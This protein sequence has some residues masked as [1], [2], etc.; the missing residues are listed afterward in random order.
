[1]KNKI[2][3]IAD[4]D[5]TTHEPTSKFIVWVRDN[6][7]KNDGLIP[8]FSRDQAALAMDIISPQS[9]KTRGRIQSRIDFACYRLGL[10][11]L[12]LTYAEPYDG[13]WE[14]GNG[15]RYSEARMKTAAR[16]KVWTKEEFDEV[17][18]FLST[19]RTGSYKLWKDEARDE[20]EKIQ[21]WAD[22]FLQFDEWPSSVQ[23]NPG[24]NPP[25]RREELILAL[26][27][28][29][30]HRDVIPSK[31]ST[32][33]IYLSN[34]LNTIGR[35]SVKG[36]TYRNASG[37]YMKLMNFRSIDP[38][39]TILGR[40]GLTR[41]NKDEQVVWDL[42]ANDIPR[43]NAIVAT[44]QATTECDPAS[45]GIEDLDEN[46]IEDC[47]EGR[48]LTR[49]HRYRERNRDL[50]SRFKARA[51]VLNHGTL[52][53]AACDLEYAGKYGELAEKLIDV[54]HTK[55]IHTMVP[56]EKTRIKD[57]VLLC[58]CCHRAIHSKRQWLQ[59]SEL[60]HILDL[61]A[62]KHE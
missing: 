30:H 35:S 10:P 49:M 21:A 45:I 14:D 5:A 15:L 24:K 59:V 60:R 34:F 13:S 26:H 9:G 4:Y 41:N 17:V 48:M 37:V 38:R 43:L 29:L 58:V 22:S 20:P 40:V 18:N 50:V 11:P 16:A 25:W 46:D 12:G 53:C 28:Y 32:Q 62:K 1:M 51:K 33:V 7:L 39:F 8:Q 56:G 36:G 6:A 23:T 2:N 54:H 27:L 3:K 61:N 31:G 57:L 19:L 44:L 42:F 52:P 47:E 55:P